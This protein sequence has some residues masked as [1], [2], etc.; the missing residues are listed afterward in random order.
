MVLRNRK[1]KIISSESKWE[2]IYNNNQSIQ[3]RMQERI[4]EISLIVEHI[5]QNY[6]NINTKK[7]K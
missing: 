5:L 4:N 2:I 1:Y 6:Y 3:E 7:Y